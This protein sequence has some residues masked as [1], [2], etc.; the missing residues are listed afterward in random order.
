MDCTADSCDEA[1]RRCVHTPIPG[2]CVTDADCDDGNP[3][4]D[5]VCEVGQCQYSDNQAPCEDGLF[6][7]VDDVCAGGECTPGPPRE[8]PREW[9]WERKAITFDHMFREK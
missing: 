5:D 6:C 2:C 8:L 4:T 7:T 3:C 1:L 9:R